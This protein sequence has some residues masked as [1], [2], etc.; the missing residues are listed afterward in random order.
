MNKAVFV[1]I[2]ETLITTKSGKSFP[3]NSE[4][5]KFKT[6]FYD[7]FKNA[8]E[9]QYKI[10]LIDNQLGIGQGFITEKIFLHKIET[11]C[12]VIE[13]DL[14]LKN[15][16]IIYTYCTDTE[17]LFRLK[18]NPGMLYELAL[19][20]EIILKDSVLIGNSEE[21]KLFSFIGGINSYYSLCQLPFISL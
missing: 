5:W 14:K 1:I 7:L 8:I 17:D 13:E 19:D 9:K 10:V 12:K 15:N 16:S 21:D 6:N 20:N 4:D 18:P 2:D 3:I 11:I